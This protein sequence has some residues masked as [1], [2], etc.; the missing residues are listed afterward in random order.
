MSP[1]AVPSR[2]P[3]AARL[4]G[5]GRCL[6]SLV[7]SLLTVVPATAEPASRWSLGLAGTN[8]SASNDF[9]STGTVERSTP[10]TRAFASAEVD[11]MEHFG[12]EVGFRASQLL[13]LK[14]GWMPGGD[15]PMSFR[16]VCDP[17]ELL[18]TDPL[19]GEEAVFLA[20]TFDNS[21]DTELGIDLTTLDVSLFLPLSRRTSSEGRRFELFLGPTLALLDSS[22]RAGEGLRGVDLDVEIENDL[23][24]H[25]GL[26]LRATSSWTIHATTRWFP[27]EIALDYR[28]NVLVEGPGDDSRPLSDLAI[29][30]PLGSSKSDWILISLGTSWRF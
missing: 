16:A 23:G 12:F 26:E 5:W 28:P 2:N 13:G 9:A 15:L 25:L 21:L 30:A 10:E 17:C 4:P 22:F 18:S 24:A 14:F 29:N 20:T 11:D 27:A 19:T 6:A 1:R 3:T 8:L 7:L